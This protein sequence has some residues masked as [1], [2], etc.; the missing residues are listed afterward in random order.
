[1]AISV[2]KRKQAQIA[3]ITAIHRDN[4]CDVKVGPERGVQLACGS[5]EGFSTG[6]QCLSGISRTVSISYLTDSPLVLLARNHI[7]H[8]G[9]YKQCQERLS[10]APSS[11]PHSKTK[12]ISGV[13][14]PS[15]ASVL[16]TVLW[17]TLNTMA[18]R[19]CTVSD[20]PCQVMLSTL[21]TGLS[22]WLL[23]V[24]PW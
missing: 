6:W 18:S 2:F 9:E 20:C 23:L 4:A 16:L 5:R 22:A 1:M 15:T 7:K 11:F 10:L 8:R 17:P 21:Q 14:A 12:A 19:R 13:A 24:F 3:G